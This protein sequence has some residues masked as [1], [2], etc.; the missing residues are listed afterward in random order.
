MEVIDSITYLERHGKAGADQ[1]SVLPTFRV[2][3][4]YADSIP[5][6]VNVN[7]HEIGWRLAERRLSPI[8]TEAGQPI[9]KNLS[10]LVK[11]KVK[12]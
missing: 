2:S 7:V 8:P 12:F 4:D 9:R 5:V 1:E 6:S 3:A 11:F 10:F